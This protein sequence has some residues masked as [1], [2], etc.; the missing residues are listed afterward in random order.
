MK[1]L[2]YTLLSL[3]LFFGIFATSASA[4]TIKPV[5]YLYNHLN[6]DSLYTYDKNEANTLIGDVDMLIQYGYYVSPVRGVPGWNFMQIAW[7]APDEGEPIYR[8]YCPVNGKHL[9]TSDINEVNVLT[10]Q[11]GWLKDNNGAPSLYS[12]GNI[13]IYRLYDSKFQMHHFTASEQEYN[14]EFP[15]RGWRQEGIKFYGY[16]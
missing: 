8:L 7:K 12:G 10:S 4:M 1:K 14:V 16:K 13:P 11:H 5:Y 15:G 3:L 6:G 9:Y 2:I